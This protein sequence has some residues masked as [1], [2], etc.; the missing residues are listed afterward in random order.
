[1]RANELSGTVDVSENENGDVVLSFL[2]DDGA[3][4]YFKMNRQSAMHL[5]SQLDFYARRGTEFAAMIKREDA[6][7]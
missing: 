6:N 2:R 5:A 3:Y 7:K 1:M 4:D